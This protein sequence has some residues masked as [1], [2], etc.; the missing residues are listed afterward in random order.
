MH[1]FVAGEEVDVLLV[2]LLAAPTLSDNRGW[3]S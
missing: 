3:G 2:E 1:L